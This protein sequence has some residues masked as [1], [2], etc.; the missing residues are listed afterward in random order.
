MQTYHLNI[1]SLFA[2]GNYNYCSNKRSSWSFEIQSGLYKIIQGGNY[3]L[4][5][6]YIF[7]LEGKKM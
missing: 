1:F 6:V 2:A 3:A 5:F 4:I 7:W